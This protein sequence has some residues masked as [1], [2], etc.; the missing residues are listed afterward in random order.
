VIAG[1]VWPRSGAVLIAGEDIT[2][3]SER[4]LARIRRRIGMMFQ[5]GALLDSMTVFENLALP[6][7]EHTKMSRTEIADTVHERLAAV[8]LTNV[9]DLLPR[10]LSGGMVKRVALARAIIADPEILLCDE[11][12]SGLDPISTKRIEALLREI[13]HEKGTTMI[14]VSHHIPSTMRMADRVLALLP[15]G[16][17]EGTPEELKKSTD[18]RVVSFLDEDAAIELAEGGEVEVLPTGGGKR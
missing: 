18:A 7:R 17:V 6:L 5:G 10:Q 3:L 13:N 14:V 9:D 4:K 1:L 2:K 8:G 11:P 12:F 15:G 16:A